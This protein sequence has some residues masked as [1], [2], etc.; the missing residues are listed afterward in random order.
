MRCVVEILQ[1]DAHRPVQHLIHALGRDGAAC[2]AV[3]TVLVGDGTTF[4]DGEIGG[5]DILKGQVQGRVVV[6]LSA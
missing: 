5:A 2:D 1:V 6:D 3:H 4:H